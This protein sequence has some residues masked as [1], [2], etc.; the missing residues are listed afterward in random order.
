MLADRLEME[1][2]FPS[3]INGQ[4]PFKAGSQS[5]SIDRQLGEGGDDL[6]SSP[7]LSAGF[8]KEPTDLGCYTKSVGEPPLSRRSETLGEEEEAREDGREEEGG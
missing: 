2:W 8:Y 4:E 6:P 7:A 1:T 5:L 3:V